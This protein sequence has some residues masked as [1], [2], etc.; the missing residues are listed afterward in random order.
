MLD[1]V[2]RLRLRLGWVNDSI[3]D[4]VWLHRLLAIQPGETVL[5]VGSG[6]TPHPRANVLCDRYVADGHERHGQPL[7]ADRPL[8]VA[9]VQD[10]PFAD[11][12]FDVVICRHVLEHVEDPVGAAAELSRV[13]RRG[14]VECPSAEWEKVAGFEFHRWLVARDGSTL[15]FRRKAGPL[16]DPSLR[17]WFMELQRA[18]GIAERVWFARREIGVYTWL[19]WRDRIDVAVDPRP[20][21]APAGSDRAR[22][23]PG[24]FSDLDSG[25]GLLGRVLTAIGRVRRRRTDL[26]WA[27]LAQRLVCPGCGG[28]YVYRSRSLRCE[29]CGREVSVDERGV[30]GFVDPTPQPETGAA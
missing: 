15:M 7:I 5:D 30:A 9:D 21:G 17:E 4:A 29:S 13:G 1:Q 26:S 23:A 27:Q 14:Y 12:S 11:N 3:R 16:F 28:G 18:T 2:R 10:L 6:G 22:T 25:W 19:V 20:A 24:A 8:V